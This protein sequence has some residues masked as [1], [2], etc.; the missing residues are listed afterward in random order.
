MKS[1]GISPDAIL[2]ALVL[3]GLAGIGALWKLATMLAEIRGQVRHNGGS[4]LKDDAA[5]AAGAAEE[6]ART[7]TEAKAVVE[8][9]EVQIGE[10][11]GAAQQAAELAQQAARLAGVAATKAATAEQR[12]AERHV[13]NV[14]RL[15]GLER[16]RI[17]SAWR[18][19]TYLAS[20][21]ELGLDITPTA[22]RDHPRPPEPS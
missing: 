21:R 11:R 13:E 1:S 9:I 10:A 18:E 6:A 2:A 15:D 4:T 16:E 14:D 20:L 17:A 3:V 19:Q 5:K 7:A 12:A 22:P 8:R